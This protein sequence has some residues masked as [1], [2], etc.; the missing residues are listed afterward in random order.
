[1]GEAGDIKVH[2]LREPD[3][4][5]LYLSL[6]QLPEGGATFELRT[7]IDP[8]IIQAAALDAVKAIDPRR[9]VDSVK[10]LKVQINDSFVQERLVGSLSALFAMLALLLTCVGLYGL[11]TYIV[12]RRTGEIGIR[13]ALGAERGRIARMVLCE[14]LVLVICGFVVGLPGAAF[15]SQLIASQLFGLRPWDPMTFLT[16]CMLWATVTLTASYMPARRA[17]SVRSSA[18]MLSIGGFRHHL[19]SPYL[20]GLPFLAVVE[21]YKFRGSFASPSLSYR[22]CSVTPA[23]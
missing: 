8:A 17:A 7:A 9:P 5:M 23:L 19:S 6:F 2:D 22:H 20:C 11:M 13:M 3:S 1:V 10:T 14:T 18:R 4:L 21:R 12:N 15:A 16:A